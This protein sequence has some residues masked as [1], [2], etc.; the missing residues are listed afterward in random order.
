MFLFRQDGKQTKMM[1]L[2]SAQTVSLQQ[3]RGLATEARALRAEGKDLPI[4]H[5]PASPIP[6]SGALADELVEGVEA[7]FRNEKHRSAHLPDRRGRRARPSASIGIRPGRS[8]SHGTAR[9]LSSLP[10]PVRASR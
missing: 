7:G 9:A 8:Q 3:A 6:T 4:A 5:K 1:G 10:E 2:G